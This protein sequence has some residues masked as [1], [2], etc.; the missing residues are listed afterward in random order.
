VTK[1]PRV[2]KIFDPTKLDAMN[3]PLSVRV[4]KMKGGTRT[5]IPLP[6]GEDG[7]L[8]GTNWSKEDVGGLEQWLV[9]EWA[10]GGM[11][12]ITVLDSSMPS[13]MK[14]DWEVFYNP[15][16]YPEK[17]P[18][19]L[20]ASSLPPAPPQPLQPSQPQVRS[21]STFPNG[22]PSGLQGSV[23][24]Q[25]VYVDRPVH[26]QPLPQ[27]VQQQQPFQPVNPML[28]ANA[29]ADAERRRY[30]D[31]LKVMSDQLARQR[32]EMLQ[33]QFRQELDRKLADAKA[34]QN[35]N[36]ERFSRMEQLIEKMITTNSRPGV[37]PALEQLKEQNRMLAAQA[38][39][40]RRER[41]A[42]RREREMKDLIR[43]QAE[44]SRRQIEAMNAQLVAQQL[45]VN[46][47]PDPMIMFLQ[48]NAR[49]QVEATKEAARNQTTQ[50]A[51]LQSFM[52]NPRDI[53]A[54]T[55]ESSNGLDNVTRQITSTYQSIL[56]MQRSAVEQI[57]QLNQGGGNETIQLIEKGLDRASSFA[58]RFIGG[59]T[60]EAV[61]QQQ[62]QAQLAQAN[63]AAMQAQAQAM[64][65]QASLQAQA[66]R[67]QQLQPAASGLNGLN[68]ARVATP[69][70]APVAP[71]EPPGDAWGTG[72]V[73]PGATVQM[74]KRTLGHTDEEW[75]GPIMPKVTELRD[76]VSHFIDSL[77]QSPARLKK[78]GSVDGVEPGQAAS[79]ILQAAMIVMQQQI[80]ITA[81][82]E[83]LGQGRVA[84]FMDV[85]LPDAPQPYRD[86]VAQMVLKELNGGDADDDE[87][88]D[89][90][91]E[92][93]DDEAED[94]A[95]Q[96]A[97]QP[98]KPAKPAPR[99]RA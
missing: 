78:D 97:A 45:T 3:E 4:E 48:E 77:K 66:A 54:M 57:L 22:L 41:E 87:D 2:S 94:V 99:A 31:Q 21:M 9:N 6:P 26:Q 17:I 25:V 76:G 53:M 36:N 34:E 73:P 5:P 10:G 75:F 72:P 15:V 93:E 35:A 91:D 55:K 95:A 13:P 46:K 90:E 33:A 69:S 32:E 28:A 40:E 8:Q 23:P 18:P 50:M 61:S 84:D 14:H 89:D 42:E 70:P 63:A 44:D 65:A 11:Y 96:P 59:K 49:Q 51:Q 12:A 67:Q 85:L 20:V 30:E 16:N 83:L 81:M 92:G 60:K 39:N 62:T 68:G 98:A 27:P 37:D 29:A 7:S 64:S 47:G 79:V 43:Q 71:P 24:Q 52:M 19:T 82:I 86:E 38:E 58:E 56:E 74:V 88:E 80:P 1:Q